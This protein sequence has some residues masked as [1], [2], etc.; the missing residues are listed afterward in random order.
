MQNVKK[1][2]N[3]FFRSLFSS[4]SSDGQVKKQ[5]WLPSGKSFVKRPKTCASITDTDKKAQN[6]LL[7]FHQ[8]ILWTC[9]N[10]VLTTSPKCF[11]AKG[12]SFF[13]KCHKV[14][15]SDASYQ[16]ESNKWRYEQ[17]EGSFGTTVGK[18]LTK[19]HT[20][21]APCPKLLKNR[22]F[23]KN[24]FF[25]RKHSSWYIECSLTARSTFSRKRQ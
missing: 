11:L 9:E 7:F 12:W 22:F 23:P 6:F 10:E 5:Y 13:V 14:T 8:L 21:S 24:S 25:S 4:K 20:F 18:K 15:R 3:R 1:T 2:N 19:G 17:V 16:K